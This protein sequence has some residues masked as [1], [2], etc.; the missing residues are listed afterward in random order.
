MIQ[1]HLNEHQEKDTFEG[2][3]A[4]E[5]SA[6]KTKTI[7]TLDAAANKIGEFLKQNQPRMGKA[8]RSKEVK[9]NITDPESAKMTTS[10]GTIQGY[11]GVAAVDKK[12]QIIIDA[13]AFGEGQ[14]HHTLKPVLESI[15]SH[16]LIIERVRVGKSSLH[17]A[18]SEHQPIPTG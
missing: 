12:H 13:H 9:S 8:K 6:R 17:L 1:Y 4:Q 18:T 11:N 7:Q 15:K 10:K 2:E 14:E 16:R 3:E 5:R